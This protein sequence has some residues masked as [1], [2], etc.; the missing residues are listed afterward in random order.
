MWAGP[1]NHSM[2]TPMFDY[3]LNIMILPNNM[4]TNSTHGRCVVVCTVFLFFCLASSLWRDD[5]SS[6]DTHHRRA[7]FEPE[8]RICTMA[9]F[10]ALASSS[11]SALC[12]VI[13]PIRSRYTNTQHAVLHTCR[14]RDS[15]ALFDL[16]HHRDSA[17]TEAAFE[18]LNIVCIVCLKTSTGLLHFPNIEL[19]W[20][21]GALL[22]A[23]IMFP[24]KWIIGNIEAWCIDTQ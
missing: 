16:A 14:P 23:N 1:P 4:H 20:W 18:H 2:R 17:Q 12:V 19:W 22:L 21:W 7:I 6:V 11:R 15:T 13:L 9:N 24:L 5:L 10:F 3:I 8:Q